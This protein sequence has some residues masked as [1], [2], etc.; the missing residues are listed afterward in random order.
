[1]ALSYFSEMCC[2]ASSGKI[3]LHY[4]SLFTV[5]TL[6]G[7]KNEASTVIG[8]RVGRGLNIHN[9]RMQNAAFHAHVLQ[10]QKQKQKKMHIHG[11]W[12]F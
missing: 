8:T 10:P 4:M 9:P 2:T 11:K 12:L 3:L 6:W 1:M 7:S 5:T